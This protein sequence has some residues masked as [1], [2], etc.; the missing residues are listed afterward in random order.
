MSPSLPPAAQDAFASLARSLFP[1]TAVAPAGL[2]AERI[3]EL[4]ARLLSAAAGGEGAIAMETLRLSEGEKRAIGELPRLF[5]AGKR[6]AF[7]AEVRT[8]IAGN[9]GV[10]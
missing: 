1:S 3:R 6:P 9:A 4:L 2:S 8:S 5:C 7:A 10:F